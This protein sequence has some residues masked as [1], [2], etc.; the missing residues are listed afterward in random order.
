[1]KVEAARG[2]AARAL[3]VDNQSK[4]L[5]AAESKKVARAKSQIS[6]AKRD[7]VAAV[8]NAVTPLKK[9]LVVS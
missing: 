2:D 9:K 3:A 6:K 5:A 8:S 1:L 7:A 4:E